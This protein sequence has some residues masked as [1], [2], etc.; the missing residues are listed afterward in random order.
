MPAGRPSSV[1]GLCRPYKNWPVMP[2]QG[3]ESRRERAVRHRWRCRPVQRFRRGAANLLATNI[4]RDRPRIL[5]TDKNLDFE[6]SKSFIARQLD[7]LMELMRFGHKQR[8]CI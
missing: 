2:G 1:K 4:T 6:F 3:S 7:M 8:L 5:V